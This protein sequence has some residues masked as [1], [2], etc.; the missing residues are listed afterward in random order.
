MLLI[1]VPLL[2]FAV[3]DESDVS[4]HSRRAEVANLKERISE[5]EEELAM[6]KNRGLQQI[7]FISVGQVCT[8]SL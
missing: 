2:R 6:E 4:D 7:Y 8:T 5:L 3:S 1:S